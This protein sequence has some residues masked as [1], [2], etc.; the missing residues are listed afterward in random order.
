MAT[1]SSILAWRNPWREQP[2]GLQ[3][4][5][6]QRVRHNW[7]DLARTHT[8]VSSAE[9]SALHIGS[10]LVFLTNLCLSFIIVTPSTGPDRN[11]APQYWTPH[12]GMCP[13]RRPKTQQPLHFQ[14][15]SSGSRTFLFQALAGSPTSTTL[16]DVFTYKNAHYQQVISGTSLVVR[17]LRLDAPNAGD[18]A[19]IPDQGTRSHMPQ[20]KIP[21]ATTKT[22]HRQINKQNFLSNFRHEKFQDGKRD[23][24]LMQQM[25]MDQFLQARTCPKQC[26][27]P[28]SEK[29]CL[30]SRSNPQSS[31]EGNL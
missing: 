23:L 1:H 17:W 20:L 30:T 28:N 11:R 3:S 27:Y 6:S 22:Q 7:S 14:K 9:M 8:C 21:S 10:H 12:N 18:P 31:G 2:G 13:T 5:V 15:T 29:P 19:S 4:I 24:C 26:K 16:N 25:F